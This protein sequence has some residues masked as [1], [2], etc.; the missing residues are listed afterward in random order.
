MIKYPKELLKLITQLQQL[1]GVGRK[2]AERFAFNLLKW[3]ENSLKAFGQTIDEIKK[4]IGNCDS[5]GC[6]KDENICNFCNP[7][8]R[9]IETICIISSPRDAYAIDQTNNYVGLYHV[10]DNLLSPLDGYNE[11]H[12]HLDKLK[13]R[14]EQLKIKEIILALDSTLEGDATSLFLKEEFSFCNVRISRLA[15][16]LPVGSSL[17]YIDE[18]TLSRALSGRQIF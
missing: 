13:K 6:I 12:L 8:K 14:I 3:E 17:E 15:F 16:G 11:S 2:T 18:G 4:K 1:P 10:I 5:C 9:N 7:V